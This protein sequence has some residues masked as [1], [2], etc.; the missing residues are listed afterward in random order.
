MLWVDR[1]S[2]L[3][4]M[5]LAFR[6][7]PKE[8]ER[9][10]SEQ[11]SGTTNCVAAAAPLHSYDR[12]SYC[13]T[14][15]CIGLSLK[16]ALLLIGLCS[17]TSRNRIECF[18]FFS[19]LALLCLRQ[20]LKITTIP[21]FKN[22]FRY[23]PICLWRLD[24]LEPQNRFALNQASRTFAAIA[25]LTIEMQIRN[26]LFFSW[27]K[28]EPLQSPLRFLRIP[29]SNEKKIS[30]I[31]IFFPRIVVVMSIVKRHISSN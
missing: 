17:F 4:R 22:E 31:K 2:L 29:F 1:R 20:K 18:F 13:S 19:F 24:W 28:S 5:C 25:H 23:F 12:C 7:R 27:L 9:H 15:V 3:R 10:N 6:A 14:L 11:R 26:A 30:N 16:I 21:C 8:A